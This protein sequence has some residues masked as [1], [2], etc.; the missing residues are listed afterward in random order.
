[1]KTTTIYLCGPI[2]GMLNGNREAF[3]KTEAFYKNLGYTVI[4]PHTVADNMP[5]KTECEIVKTELSSITSMVNCIAL[6]PGWKNSRYGLVE[7]SLGLAYG[8]PFIIAGTLINVS[9]T[10]KLSAYETER[11]KT[12]AAWDNT[13]APAT[14]KQPNG[15]QEPSGMCQDMRTV[16]K[17]T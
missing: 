6:L 2:T 1:M 13:T 17:A 8:I 10:I 14:S 4:N 11:S 15:A 9:P 5:G 7:V 3:K 12:L 16:K